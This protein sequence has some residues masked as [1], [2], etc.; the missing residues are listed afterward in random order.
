MKYSATLKLITVLIVIGAVAYLYNDI[1]FWLKPEVITETK[2]DTVFVSRVDT[3]FEVNSTIKK[4]RV[5]DTLTITDTIYKDV[6]V[7]VSDTVFIQD[8]SMVQVR[9]FFPPLDYFEIN[10]NIRERVITKEITKRICPKIS[11]GIQAGAGVDIV[12]GVPGIYLGFGLQYNL[13]HL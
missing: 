2:I 9:Y 1:Q 10:A 3:V 4:I 13:G 12:S 6:D 11:Y 8:S 7:A 5:V